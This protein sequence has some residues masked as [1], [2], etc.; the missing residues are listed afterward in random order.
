MCQ[1][2]A[3]SAAG[4]VPC[5]QRFLDSSSY[6]VNLNMQLNIST[7]PTTWKSINTFWHLQPEIAL[8]K[9]GFNGKRGKVPWVHRQLN[10]NLFYIKQE[11]E[12][13]ML[14]KPGM[15]KDLHPPASLPTFR[16][17]FGFQ[18]CKWGDR[19]HVRKFF[20]ITSSQTEGVCVLPCVL[21]TS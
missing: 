8:A 20:E 16:P 15:W 12:D 4:G 6:D 5:E 1:H 14:G 2:P 7:D 19:R 9:S 3:G 18:F 11:P 13:N 21:F 17:S 10:V